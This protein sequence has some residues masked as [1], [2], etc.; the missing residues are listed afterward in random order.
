MILHWRKCHFGCDFTLCFL[1]VIRRATSFTHSSHHDIPGL[2]ELRKNRAWNWRQT[3][4]MR[5]KT[6]PFFPSLYVKGFGTEKS[7]SYSRY[8][9][10]LS[11]LPFFPLY[12]RLLY[13]FCPSFSIPRVLTPILFILPSLF[14]LNS[15]FYSFLSLSTLLKCEALLWQRH[16]L[17]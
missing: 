6:R 4:E 10:Q 15:L 13:F 11:F 14:L 16:D 9:N 17:R 7:Y 1:S 3:F 2:Q 12:L 8:Y 5:S